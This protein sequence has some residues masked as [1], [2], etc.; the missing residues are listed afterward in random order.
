MKKLF[1]R[2]LGAILDY[3]KGYIASEDFKKATEDAGKKEGYRKRI[4]R[5]K[6][7]FDIYIP[8][9]RVCMKYPNEFF[10]SLPY[11]K[12]SDVVFVPDGDTDMVGIYLR[13]HYL[14]EDENDIKIRKE[15]HPNAVL[16]VPKEQLPDFLTI[17]GKTKTVRFIPLPQS[18]PDGEKFQKIGVYFLNNLEAKRL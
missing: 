11:V 18:R 12:D 6:K 17:N 8:N 4:E 5:L 1:D 14:R 3:L 10:L 16:S 13:D 7:D 15:N 9:Y 2:R